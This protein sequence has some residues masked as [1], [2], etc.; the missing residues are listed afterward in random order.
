MVRAIQI[1]TLAG[2][3]A[4]HSPLTHLLKLLYFAKNK[5]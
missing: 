5:K 3:A 4:T 1:S 2:A